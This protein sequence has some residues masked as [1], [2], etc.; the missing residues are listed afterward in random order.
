MGLLKPKGLLSNVGNNIPNYKLDRPHTTALH[1]I[2]A[3]L[4]GGSA[5]MLLYAIFQRGINCRN[6]GLKFDT[7]I[8]IS[9]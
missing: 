3:L 6:R 1:P 9:R 2:R 8:R 5:I 4:G 7:G